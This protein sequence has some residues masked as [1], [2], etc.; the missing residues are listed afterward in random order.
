M[1]LIRYSL[2]FTA[3]QLAYIKDFAKDGTS[4]SEHIRTAVDDYIM[5]KNKSIVSKSPS[6]ER[7]ATWRT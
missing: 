4:Q 5:K 7:R 6:K 1:P 3:R 2:H